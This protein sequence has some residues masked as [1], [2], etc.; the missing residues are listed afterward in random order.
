MGR[1]ERKRGRGTY[2]SSYTAEP[3]RGSRQRA[4]PPLRRGGGSR[5]LGCRRG[6]SC[7]RGRSRCSCLWCPSNPLRRYFPFPVTNH[8]HQTQTS[9]PKP[10][11]SAI[12]A[13]GK[14][15]DDGEEQQKKKTNRR[16]RILINLKPPIRPI[17]RRRILHSAQIP[18]H[19][20]EM[21]T[22]DRLVRARP[23]IRLLVHLD[24]HRGAG[25]YSAFA[26]DAG[27]AADVAAEVRGGYV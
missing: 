11:S 7:S 6:S 15:S 1:R 2:S 26:G 12:T 9:I 23:V 21:V 27:A 10:H 3:R 19:R 16:P 20:P 24:R 25:C 5:L 18:Q 13:K 22:P 14:R 8:Q 17:R 4:E